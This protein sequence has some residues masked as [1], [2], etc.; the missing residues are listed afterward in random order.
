M[1]Q[2]MSYKQIH[3]ETSRY[4]TNKNKF[5]Y[6]KCRKYCKPARTEIKVFRVTVLL[7]FT[8]LK[9]I[10]INIK[11]KHDIL[12]FG[13]FRICLNTDSIN[14]PGNVTGFKFLNIC[15]PCPRSIKNWCEVFIHCGNEIVMV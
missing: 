8:N 14:K 3:V 11:N 15:L 9:I 2:Y 5:L 7:R 4:F 12:H 1:T 6:F 10:F 13:D